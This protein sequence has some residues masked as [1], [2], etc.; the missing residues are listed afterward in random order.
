[1]HEKI[2]EHKSLPYRNVGGS[3]VGNWTAGVTI[4]LVAWAVLTVIGIAISLG[5]I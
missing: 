4:T 3:G 2:F 5:I 1:L